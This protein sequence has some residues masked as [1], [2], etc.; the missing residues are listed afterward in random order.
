[1]ELSGNLLCVIAVVLFVAYLLLAASIRVVPEY[2]RLSVYR[3]G[4]YIG[5][6]GPGL[7]FLIPFLDRGVEKRIDTRDENA[8]KQEDKS[9]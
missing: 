6:K 1:M 8:P 2:T 7:V 4:Q 3:F 5:D 9:A